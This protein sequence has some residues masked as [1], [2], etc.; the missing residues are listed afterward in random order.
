MV[1][2]REL[3]ETSRRLQREIEDERQYLHGLEEENRRLREIEDENVLLKRLPP[4]MNDT[5]L[6]D[7]DLEHEADLLRLAAAA[8][9]V[10]PDIDPGVVH[11]VVRACAGYQDGIKPL[12]PF[13]IFKLKRQ[14][15]KNNLIGTQ[16]ERKMLRFQIGCKSAGLLGGALGRFAAQSSGVKNIVLMN[17]F[18]FY[19]GIPPCSSQ[20]FSKASQ[21]LSTQHSALSRKTPSNP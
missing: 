10:S 8:V 7:I 11:G 4:K 1:R 3:E 5:T 20:Y 16:L 17:F 9:L 19:S 15:Y 12:S 2:L 18:T 14:K 21:K 6:L 13:W